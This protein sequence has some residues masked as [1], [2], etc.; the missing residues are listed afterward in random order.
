MKKILVTGAAGFIGYHVAE[1][2]LAAGREVVG[3]DNLNAYYD[4]ALKEARLAR[5]TGRDGFTF[6][7]ASLEDRPAMAEIFAAGRFDGVVHLGAQAG[8][9]YSLENPHAYVDANL[10]GFVNVL[11]GCRHGGV[12][13]LVYASSSSVYGANTKVPFSVHDAVDHPLS[14][15][16]ATKKA[17]ELMAHTYAHLYR[18]PVSGLRF[19]TVYGPWGRPD[20]ALFLF[21]KAILEGREID[22]FNHGEMKR[23]F[24]FVSDIVEGVVRVLDHVATPDEAW[25]SRAPDPASSA[26]PYRVYNIGNH[27]PVPLLE[28]IATLERAL[29]VS[30]KKRM[31][32]MQ[33]GDVPATY[34]DVD[35]LRD[36]V[37]FRPATPL[38]EGVAKFVSWYRSFY[39][40]LILTR[41]HRGS[42]RRSM[43]DSP[44]VFV[45]G[46]TDGIGR[47]TANELAR[48]GARLV[49]HGRNEQK[50]ATVA[51]EVARA[52]KHEVVTVRADFARLA[53]VHAMAAEL[54]RLGVVLDV[55]V[56]NAGIFAK[57]HEHTIDG[58]ESTMAVNHLAPFLLTHLVLAGSVGEKLSR[59]INVS[60]MAHARGR[61]D[62]DDPGGEKVRFEAYAAYSASKLA[63][64]LFTVELARRLGAKPTVNALHPGVVSTK[65]LTAGFNMEGSDSLAQ[66]AATSVTLALS[67][68]VAETTGRYFADGKEARP[69]AA[70][71][72]ADV[73]RKL[74]EKTCEVLDLTPITA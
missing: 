71:Q 28:L 30:A 38:A 36:A 8:V 57:H 18:L 67:P 49:L 54:E 56:N 58:Y 47:E 74:Y 24:T 33:A 9:R 40:V 12:S 65:L 17:N 69:S 32:P 52:G 70:S 64:V 51:A 37:G 31:L 62:V 39:G 61:I 35:A 21:T 22:V 4:P 63:N 19:F 53:D 23:D 14:L 20:M 34:A 15:Y 60:S 73:A 29:G 55:L 16:A 6:R 25:S 3:V 42:H 43:T 41:P 13:H 11:E 26:A 2:L 68:A 5:L 44:V 72:N 7:K 50:L 46:A 27:E 45:T 66:G 59:I 10:V 48:R 1:R